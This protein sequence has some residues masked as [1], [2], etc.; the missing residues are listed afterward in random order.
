MPKRKLALDVSDRDER[1]AWRAR[2]GSLRDNRIA[3]STLTRYK[4][5]VEKFLLWLDFESRDAATTWDDLEYQLSA[6]IEVLWK[7]GEAKNLANDTLSG[8]QHFLGTRRRI[9]GAWQLLSAWSRL[10]IPAR[11]APMPRDVALDMCGLALAR[12]RPDYCALLLLGFHGFLRPAE[13]LTVGRGTVDLP[14]SSASSAVVSLP[15]TKIGQQRGA[16]ETLVVDDSLVLFWLQRLLNDR[17]DDGTILVGSPYSFRKFMSDAIVELGLSGCGLK[18]Y[19]LRRGGATYH[20]MTF[21]DLTK[22]IFR[23][24]WSDLRVA[25]IYIVDGAA[26][27]AEMR[28]SAASQAVIKK[29]IRV[30]REHS[31]R[32]GF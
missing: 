12:G 11:A 14:A 2:L 8:T 6:Y 19:S 7:E 3:S 30:L 4:T 23:G 28:L 13:L 21:N 31:R 29:Y 25:R 15:W 18:P 5:A 20:Y 24:R 16:K 26:V 17:V 27:L 22:T 32:H 1:I 10:E 9:P